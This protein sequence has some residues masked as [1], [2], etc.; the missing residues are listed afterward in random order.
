MLVGRAVDEVVRQ[1]GTVGAHRLD[2]VD[3][4]VQL[5]E[6]EPTH[7]A[8][9][10]G[11]QVI[12]GLREWVSLGPTRTLRTTFDAEETVGVQAQRAGTEIGDGMAGVADDEAHS[13]ERWVEPVDGRL[14]GLE[15]VQV[16]P[17]PLDAV[18]TDDGRCCAPVGFLD[19]ELVEDHSLQLADDVAGTSEIG[20]G[21]GVDVLR[22]GTG[23]HTRQ[24]VPVLRLDLDHVVNAG[25]I[26]DGHLGQPEIRPLTGVAGNDVVDD[27]AVVRGSHD[28]QASELFFRSEGG[29]DLHTDA[30]EVAVDGRGGTP[31]VD[32]ARHL[33]RSGVH[34][35]DADLGERLPQLLV[36]ESAQEAGLRSVD[37]RDGV[38]GEPD[39]CSLD[40]STRVGIGIRV[41][42]H[43]ALARQLFGNELGIS[44]HR[45]FGE[46]IHVLGIGRDRL[47]VRCGTTTSVR[48][49]HGRTKRFRPSRVELFVVGDLAR[50]VLHF[51]IH[52]PP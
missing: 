31:P 33:H 34:G 15:V 11:D 20:L 48:T 40:G 37:H 39:G 45:L 21:L 7:L 16:H 13:R 12:R 43:A 8:H 6:G 42:P 41:L 9:H 27:D 51:G 24:Q 38:R 32:A 36:T 5:L 1:I 35:G 19:T 10:T 17:T 50:F 2:V 14:T 28:A 25:V 46:P 23:A 49:T 44:Q 29:V 18:D 22:V 30:V 3:R 52:V 4:Q 47:A 26:G